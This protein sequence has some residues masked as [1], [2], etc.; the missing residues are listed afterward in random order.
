MHGYFPVYS[1]VFTGT[2]A[3]YLV[4]AMPNQSQPHMETTSNHSEGGGGQSPSA[5][6]GNPTPATGHGAVWQGTVGRR[7]AHHTQCL[8]QTAEVSQEVAIGIIFL[9]DMGLIWE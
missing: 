3:V 9:Q 8:H 1:T 6:N 7:V 5:G 2:L 4:G